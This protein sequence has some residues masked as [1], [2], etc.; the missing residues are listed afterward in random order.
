MMSCNPKNTHNVFLEVNRYQNNVLP[1]SGMCPT[2]R[3]VLS[4]ISISMFY[5]DSCEERT[6]YISVGKESLAFEFLFQY[7]R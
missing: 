3:I 6:E 2:F 4:H 1:N 5:I 7:G